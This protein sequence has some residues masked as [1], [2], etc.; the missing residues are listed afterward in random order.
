[1]YR[2]LRRLQCTPKNVHL[3]TRNIATTSK[4]IVFDKDGTLLSFDKP[5]LAWC[6]RLKSGL[7]DATAKAVEED[8]TRI[9]RN[10]GVDMNKEEIGLGKFA[11]CS[12]KEVRRELTE[13]FSATLQRVS[14]DEELTSDIID[15]CRQEGDGKFAL[16]DVKTLFDDLKE[17]D[18]KI[19]IATA[20]CDQGIDM[21]LDDNSV[22]DQVDF[23]MSADNHA[24][25]PPKPSKI[26]A[27][28]LC[29]RFGV[30]SSNVV[31]VGDTP[32][33]IQFGLN[34]EYGLVVGVTTGVGSAQDLNSA[35]AHVVLDDLSELVSV[36]E[37]SH[38]GNSAEK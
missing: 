8:M 10:M 16:T 19:V 14:E 2:V 13:G 17:R 30:D 3:E 34:G 29:E 24:D 26:S 23:V 31:M 6:S 22:R 15:S 21:F 1:M 33:D 36:L 4:L 11:E 32:T 7:A 35:G 18:Y 37:D 12:Q 25:F 9:L 20:D 5:W 38:I 28:K 27:D